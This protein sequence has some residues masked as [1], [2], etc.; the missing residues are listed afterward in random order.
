M[1]FALPPEQP[2]HGTGDH[3]EGLVL[4]EK[5]RGT[6]VEELTTLLRKK[7]IWHQPGSM[8]KEDA[9]EVLFTLKRLVVAIDQELGLKDAGVGEFK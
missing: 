4:P 5:F 7:V 6:E 9:R 3:V 2:W 1:H 8:D